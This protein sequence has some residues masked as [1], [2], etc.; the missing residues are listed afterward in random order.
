[1]KDTITYKCWLPGQINNLYVDG[2]FQSYNGDIPAVLTGR[3]LAY[4]YPTH[5]PK[6]DYKYLSERTHLNTRPE[7]LPELH[8]IW[9]M[10]DP[11]PI[12]IEKKPFIQTNRPKEQPTREQIQ[13]SIDA[14]LHYYYNVRSGFRHHQIISFAGEILSL[15]I[16]ESEAVSYTKQYMRMRGREPVNGECENAVKYA[17]SH[18]S[19]ELI[20]RW[21]EI[22]RAENRNARKNIAKILGRQ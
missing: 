16:S 5:T 11:N 9:K 19:G 4:C 12:V 8:M 18:R 6:G 21:T 15:G 7:E 22:R 17:A 14:A 1:M 10:V 13:Y 2:K 3:R 20:V